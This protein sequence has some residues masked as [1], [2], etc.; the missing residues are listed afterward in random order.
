M[1]LAEFKSTYAVSSISLYKSTV[2]DRL[3]GSVQSSK[4]EFTVVTKPPFSNTEAIYAYPTEVK[5]V[6]ESTGEETVSTIIVLSNKAPKVADMV[7]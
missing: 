6:D 3:V 2:S 1:T 4:G 5:S 7:L